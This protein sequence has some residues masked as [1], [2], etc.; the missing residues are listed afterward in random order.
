MVAAP[1]VAVPAAS[2]R[3]RP[4]DRGWRGAR[5]SWRQHWELYLLMLVPLAWFA[6]FKYVP[7][8]NAI[9]AFKDYYLLEGVWGSPWVGLKHFQAFIDNPVALTLVKNTFLLSAYVLLAGFPIPIILALALN[10]VRQGL[11]RK[12]VQMV[13]Y[14]PYFISTVVV[15]SMTILVLSPQLGFVSD[16][17][18]VIG[19]PMPDLLGRAEYFRH[20]YVWSEVWQTAGYSAVI[21]LAAL[22][23]I[24]PGLY[25]AARVDGASRLQKIWHVDIPSLMPTAVI[26]LILGVGNVMAIGFEK[27]FLLQNPLN[28]GTSEIIATYVYK[29]GLLSS[30]FSMATAVG[31][32][33]SV[34]NL[35]LLLMVNAV[36]RR[37]TGSGLW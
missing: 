35:V 5:H 33:N 31:L 29:V 26:I 37:V 14:A 17:L 1:P 16:A 34:I 18:G 9:I 20:I 19:V 2:T 4:S 13:T 3:E 8:S 15:I 23:G 6:I 36:A 12:S 22:A 30:N 32:F 11:F 21:Y 25:E 28:L 27:A 10:E 24:D 7:M